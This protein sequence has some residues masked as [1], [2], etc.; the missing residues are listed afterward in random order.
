MNIYI[1]FFVSSL[2]LILFYTFSKK[3]SKSTSLYKKN[4]DDTPLVGGLGIYFFF[5]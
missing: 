3:I 5:L 4:N 1:Y 2:M